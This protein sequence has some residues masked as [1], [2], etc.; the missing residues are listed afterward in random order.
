MEISMRRAP[1]TFAP[2]RGRVVVAHPVGNHPGNAL[3]T[4]PSR[5]DIVQAPP[6]LAAAISHRRFRIVATRLL[7]PL[8][9]V[10]VTTLG[11]ASFQPNPVAC[12]IAGQ[13]VGLEKP[14]R[15]FEEHLRPRGPGAQWLP[16]RGWL[17][18]HPW[19][20]HLCRPLGHFCPG[21]TLA[22]VHVPRL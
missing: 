4:G 7:A 16:V 18:E 21:C 15:D 22:W 5:H 3:P 20:Q 12:A 19:W 9:I 14:F 8:L 11:C 1:P 2:R 13:V 17:A 6:Q 10:A